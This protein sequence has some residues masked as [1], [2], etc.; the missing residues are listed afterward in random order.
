MR[1]QLFLLAGLVAL[2]SEAQVPTTTYLMYERINGQAINDNTNEVLGELTLFIA[3]GILIRTDSKAITREF[4]VLDNKDGRKIDWDVNTTGINIE[5]KNNTR[6]WKGRVVNNFFADS[7]LLANREVEFILLPIELG[8]SIKQ[9]K[10]R[11]ATIGSNNDNNTI[12]FGDM[13]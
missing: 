3:N 9:L 5:I 4:K 13:I 2:Y 1:F 8:I 10:G 12:D 7:A 11:Y 6:Q